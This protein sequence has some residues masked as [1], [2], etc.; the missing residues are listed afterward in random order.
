M[1]QV[2]FAH[3]AAIVRATF[4]AGIDNKPLSLE[5][6][7]LAGA[8]YL[9]RSFAFASLVLASPVIGLLALVNRLTSNGP[10]FYS[11]L[12]VGKDGALFPLF[13]IRTMVVDAEATSGAVLSW[14]GD[15]RVTP[16]GKFLR[17]THLDE[18]PQLVNVIRGEMS[19]I[20]PRPERPEFVKE[21]SEVVG[22]YM[23]RH[24]AKPGITGLAQICCGYHA[25]PEE[26]LKYDLVFLRN[27]NSFRLLAFILYRTV[28]KVALQQ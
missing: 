11:Q 21:F 15:P 4:Q 16:F 2:F 17:K 28:I 18:L 26:K 10:A 20:G 1:E 9:E 14:S 27:K 25:S 6:L 8:G 24:R 7:K 13:K 5:G 22:H 3:N 12:R 23:L 19:F